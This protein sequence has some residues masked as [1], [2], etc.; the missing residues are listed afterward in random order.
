MLGR[1]LRDPERVESGI[2]EQ[3]GL[4]L[5]PVETWF[6]PAKTVFRVEAAGA[7]TSRLFAGAGGGFRAYEIHA[8]HTRPAEAAGGGEALGPVFRILGRQGRPATDVD[9]AVGP[10]GNVEGTYLHGVLADPAVR[11][12]LLAH[13]AGRKG[14]SP[15]PRW[16]GPRQADRYDRLADIV[17]DALDIGAIAKL[18]GVTWPEPPP[19]HRA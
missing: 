19:R 9:G 14:V 13:L 7:P 3:P 16:G 5:L 8:G 2:G 12:C 15:D 17:G 11:R 1:T 4:G 6:A 18:V 10:T